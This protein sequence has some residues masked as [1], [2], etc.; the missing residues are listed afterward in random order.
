MDE[1]VFGEVSGACSDKAVD[2][3]LKT[4]LKAGL[5]TTAAYVFG[6]VIDKVSGVAAFDVK[7]AFDAAF[8]IKTAFDA[9]FDVKIAFDAA[10]DVEAAFD[11][12][13][14]VETGS[15]IISS[16]AVVTC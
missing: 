8:D 12:A 2:A 4:D 5:K 14:Y 11:A 3:G 10:F 7:T 1:K 15:L 16:A 9:A 6:G 13:F